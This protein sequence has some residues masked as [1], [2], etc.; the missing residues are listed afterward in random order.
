MKEK[1]MK[2]VLVA[3][4]AVALAAVMAVPASAFENE[5]GGYFRVRAYSQSDFTGDDSGD[6]DYQVVDTRTR[7]YYTAK[8]SDDFKLVNKFEIDNTWGDGDLGDIGADCDGAI[9]V[10]NTYVDFNMGN[11][12]FKLGTQGAVIARGFVF[13]DDFSGATITGNYGNVEVPFYWMKINEGG[14]A[15]GDDTNDA[16]KDAYAVSPVFQSGNMTVNPYFVYVTQKEKTVD[17]DLFE[18]FMAYDLGVD[19]DVALGNA[20]AWFTGIYQG[21]SVD[22]NKT[23]VD[24]SSYLVAF[25]GDATLGNISVHGQMFHASGQD[26]DDPADEINAF[27]DILSESGSEDAQDWKGQSYYWAEIMG[28]GTFDPWYGSAG[29]PTD[30]ISNIT[31]FNIGASM[32]PMEKL[33]VGADLWYAMLAE[34]NAAGDDE[35]GTEIDLSASYALMDNLN[36]DVVA[37]YLMAGDATGDED[38]M[39]LGAQLSLSF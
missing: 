34:D 15:D 5:F 1:N 14:F 3:A 36:L 32:S 21:G 18:D 7:L 4:L 29:S 22:V 31:A 9:E 11:Y 2:K 16:D 38:P 24:M 25:G 23:D 26:Q 28:Y 6:R 13:W 12:N 35:L 33:T 30:K 10:K 19:L 8:F 17:G 39:E 20:N 37:A 27:V